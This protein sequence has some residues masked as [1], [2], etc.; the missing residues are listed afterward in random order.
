M[1]VMHGILDRIVPIRNAMKL[2][3]LWHGAWV[4]QIASAGHAVVFTALDQLIFLG[5]DFL[6]YSHG[7][8]G[9][10][11]LGSLFY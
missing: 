1:I 9:E 8:A 6:R 2:G 10:F 7:T 4:L 11:R 3:A 5:L